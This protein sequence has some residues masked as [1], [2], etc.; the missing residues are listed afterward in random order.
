MNPIK[1]SLKGEDFSRALIPQ[2]Q[3]QLR[4]TGAAFELNKAGTNTNLK[5]TSTL[6]QATPST[7]EGVVAQ[8]GDRNFTTWDP[9]F[10]TEGH[11]EA[12]MNPLESICRKI[13]AIF[14][15]DADSRPDL[16]QDTL[17]AMI[18]KTFIGIIEHEDNDRFGKQDRLVAYIADTSGESELG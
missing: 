9:I 18:G 4:I 14:N 15:C 13:D 7:K 17:N 16:E 6:S 8:P 5:I 1:I 12:G 10:E 2:G 3:I 11:K